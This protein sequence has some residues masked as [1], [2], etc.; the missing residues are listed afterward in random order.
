MVGP[1]MCRSASTAA[2]GGCVR[3]ELRACQAAAR[4]LEEPGVLEHHRLARRLG[5]GRVGELRDEVVTGLSDLID[6]H[7]EGF[8]YLGA[9]GSPPKKVS[10]DFWA[11]E[12][13]AVR[14][15][16]RDLEHE[17]LTQHR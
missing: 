12:L 16:G 5:D 1:V 3:V 11:G 17:V 10:E 13:P 14:Q 2:D 4:D 7:V 8:P 9:A 15:R 6:V